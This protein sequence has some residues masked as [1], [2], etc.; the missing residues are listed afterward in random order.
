MPTTKNT[1]ETKEEN[2]AV[3]D[4]GC[5]RSFTAVSSHL[6]NMQPK[7]NII[8]AKFPNE[9]II[10][11]TMERGLGLPML[12]NIARQAHAFPNIKKS[13]VSIGASCDASFT[14]TFKIKDVTVV[15]KDNISLRGWK[16]HHNT[17]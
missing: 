6:N 10:R 14:V 11:S 7:T 13:L 4:L 2:S 17:L 16:K 15:Y 8:N 12:P 1:Q 5:T 9:K 3:S